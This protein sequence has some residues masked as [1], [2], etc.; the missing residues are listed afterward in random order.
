MKSDRKLES[1][2]LGYLMEKLHDPTLICLDPVP[3][4]DRR[5][6]GETNCATC[7]QYM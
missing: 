7:S 2:G 3:V 4:C 5:T 1:L 6:D